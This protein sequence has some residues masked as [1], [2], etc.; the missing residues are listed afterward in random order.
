MSTHILHRM[1]SEPVE[2]L[3]G[4]EQLAPTWALPCSQE[5]CRDVTINMASDSDAEAT[6]E[7]M[8]VTHLRWRQ[9]GHRNLVAS[10]AH[11]VILANLTSE[12]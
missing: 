2:W 12:E 3:G 8:D 6:Q 9:G 1:R 11:S 10:H 4:V 5:E 7:F